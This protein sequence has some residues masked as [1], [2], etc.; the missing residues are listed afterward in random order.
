MDFLIFRNTLPMLSEFILKDFI[1]FQTILSFFQLHVIKYSSE[2]LRKDIFFT[3]LLLCIYL[4][5]DI[6][7]AEKN[8]LR[9]FFSAPKTTF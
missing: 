3:R 4:G 1:Y 7:L 9:H 5:C 6:R 2:K 8:S